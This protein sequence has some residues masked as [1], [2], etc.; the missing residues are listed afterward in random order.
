MDTAEKVKKTKIV[1]KEPTQ[2]RSRN[3]VNTILDA[4]ARLLVSEGFYSLTTDKI[5]KEA[6]VSIGSL[7]QFF[8]NKES[9][10]QA[11]VKKILEEDKIYF[12]ENM[13]A[14][15][16]LP[17]KERVNALI[18]LALDIVS[19]NAELRSK[20]G[21]IQ[22]Y[23]SEPGFM[24]D[25]LNY[26]YELISYNL[27]HMPDRNMKKVCSIFVNAFI[28]TMDLISV[29]TPELISDEEVKQEIKILLLNYIGVDKL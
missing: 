23:V 26:F 10:V 19:R 18:D 27:P 1:V 3:T 14:I 2:Q 7:Y 20:L 25:F 24:A 29:N 17:P 9:V 28:G 16:P 21:T 22:Y 11:L 8:G 6:G 4:C 15:S 12:S 5:A 13:R